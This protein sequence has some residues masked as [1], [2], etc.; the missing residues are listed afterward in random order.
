MF[1]FIGDD[2]NMFLFFG[3]DVIMILD[4]DT[5]TNIIFTFLIIS[6]FL[7]SHNLDEQLGGNVG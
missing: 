2:T 6:T 5:N 4:L 3:D 7:L 1:L